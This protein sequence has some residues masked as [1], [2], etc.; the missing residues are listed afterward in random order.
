MANKK[1]RGDKSDLEKVVIPQALVIADSFDRRFSPISLEM[2][3]VSTPCLFFIT[4][5]IC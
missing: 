1:G 5:F 3:R 4:V 2:P